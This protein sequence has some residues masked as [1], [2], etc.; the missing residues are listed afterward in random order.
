MLEKGWPE[1]SNGSGKELEVFSP[2]Y[3]PD[4][5]KQSRV[6]IHP[7]K[8]VFRSQSGFDKVFIS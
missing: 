5:V 1:I 8:P 2:F 3:S 7:K 6:L 4:S